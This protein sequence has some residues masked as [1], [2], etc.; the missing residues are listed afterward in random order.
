MGLPDRLVQECECGCLVIFQ[1]EAFD[2]ARADEEGVVCGVTSGLES[3]P[4]FALLTGSVAAAVA[5]LWAAVGVAAAAPVQFATK[6]ASMDPKPIRARYTPK[7]PPAVR[8]Q[9]AAHV[10]PCTEIERLRQSPH[11]HAAS[12]SSNTM[13][14]SLTRL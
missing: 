10:R 2:Y 13:N 7:E 5:G 12:Q 1:L 11:K 8:P 14:R 9:P 4:G 3:L 6:R